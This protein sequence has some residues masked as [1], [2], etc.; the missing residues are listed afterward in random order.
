MGN[1]SR[2]TFDKMKHYV[3]VRLQQG[4]PIVDADWNEMEDIRKYE[5]QAFL[6]WFVGDGVPQGN[7]GFHIVAVPVNDFIIKAGRCLVDGWD[8]INDDRLRYTTQRLYKYPRLARVWKVPPLEELEPPPEG[9]DRT[10][11]VYLDAWEREV[12]SEGDYEHLVHPDIGIETCVRLKR[13]W[14]VRVREGTSVPAPGDPDYRTGHRYYALAT[15]TRENGDGTIHAGDITDLRERRLLLPPATLITDLFDTSPADYRRGLGRP[16]IS[17]RQAINALLRGQ[18][19]AT[20]ETAIAPDPNSDDHISRGTFFD[21]ENGLITVWSSD[22]VGGVRQV[23]AAR[24]SLDDPDGGFG[25]PQRVTTGTVHTIPH[26]LLLDSGEVL[27]IYQSGEVFEDGIDGIYL[28]RAA[29]RDLN[30]SVPEIEVA[31]GGGIG[32]FTE[33]A[34]FAIVVD[35]QV[36]ILWADDWGWNANRFDLATNTFPGDRKILP[37]PEEAQVTVASLHAAKGAANSVWIAFELSPES[38]Q[39]GRHAIRVLEMP[40]RGAPMNEATLEPLGGAFGI[41]TD[42]FVAVD[43]DDNAWVFW[44]MHNGSIWYSRFLR[45][46]GTWEVPTEIP[47]TNGG[48]CPVAVADAEGYIW[49]FWQSDR[50]G[51][52][53]IWSS[54]F[55]PVT[56][57]WEEPRRITCVPEDDTKPFI[58]RGVNGMLWLFWNRQLGP[59]KELFYRRII[60]SI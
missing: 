21:A 48:L 23:F 14:V 36:L 59:N 35:E 37:I 54:R 19:P 7:D 11:L 41:C 2:D 10:D 47:G 12:D 9:T 25:T 45:T 51:S 46:P 39:S 31:T 1:F 5:L 32:N 8:V 22:R 4:V 57:D 3:G 17:F 18:V 44:R 58:L 30:T 53:D 29:F 16:P 60:T 6:K 27:V 24:L 28:K 55:I 26:A 33:S 15:I 40:L 56:G 43:N 20:P 50:S 34:P 38:S 49:L 52:W 42:P 13:E